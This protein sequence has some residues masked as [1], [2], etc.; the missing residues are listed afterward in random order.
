MTPHALTQARLAEALQIGRVTYAN[1]EL[2]RKVPSFELAL[3]IAVALGQP[4]EILFGADGRARRDGEAAGKEMDERAELE[5]SR[6]RA[7]FEVVREPRSGRPY[8]EYGWLVTL[9][10]RPVAR[11][12][13]A[14]HRFP[15]LA[16][17]EAE[18]VR[19]AVAGAEPTT[20]ATPV[21][22]S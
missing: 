20:I 2:G 6:G 19:R 10:G 14:P 18:A 17:A 15:V 16:H 9:D 12:T 5:R 11:S 22:A 7:T 3:R 4:V 8:D 1:I 13:S 21:R